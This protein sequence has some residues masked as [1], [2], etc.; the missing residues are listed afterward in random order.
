MIQLHGITYAIGPR[1]LFDD[2]DWV[3]GPGDRVALVGPNGAG[4][5]TLLKVLLGE[6][7]PESGNRVI[8]KG[9]RLGYLPQE[10]AEKF[11]GTVLDRALEA[12][13]ATLDM[14]EELD[15][16]HQRLAGIA[17][18]DPDLEA[19]L[20]RSGELQHHLDITDEHALEPEARR[21]LSGLGFSQADQDRP[22]EEF[23]G[24]WRMRA[25]LAAL[26][27][28]DPTLLFLDEPTNHLDL[29][30]MEWLEDY[31]EDFHGGLVV[32][33]HDRVFL[34]NVATTVREL[35]RGQMTEFAT[36][37]TGYL[38]ERE[39]R[40]ERAEAANEQL[41]KKVAQLSRFVERFGAKNTMASRAQSKRKMIERLKKQ[42]IVL[43]RKP[44]SIRFT[45]PPPPPT[46]RTGVR[47]NSEPQT[48]RVSFHRPRCFRSLIT[49]ANG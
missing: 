38:E 6:Y 14:R 12:H 16:L 44:R 18:E 31:L 27:L 24:G 43:P 4:K 41:D 49:A 47:P 10:A 23:S 42:H 39:T 22:L 1:I 2:L 15:L 19:L 7:R 25:T 21:V 5:T 48:T 3:L 29:P 11:E 9:T 28:T 26:L 40:R 30:A 37:F 8:A 35:D 33:S 34:D 36:S 17:P 45:F 20:E 32:V 46:S 13:R